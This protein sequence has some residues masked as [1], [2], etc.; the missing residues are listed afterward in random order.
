[1][2]LGHGDIS[3]SPSAHSRR[4]SFNIPPDCKKSLRRRL[5]LARYYYTRTPAGSERACVC[6]MNDPLEPPP[7]PAASIMDD[8]GA[9]WCAAGWLAGRLGARRLSPD[10]MLGSLNLLHSFLPLSFS[11]AVCAA[12]WV[13]ISTKQ[14]WKLNFTS[15]EHHLLARA[16]RQVHLLL[17][18]HARRNKVHC[19][20]RP[21]TCTAEYC[22]L[23][24][25]IISRPFFFCGPQSASAVGC[26]HLS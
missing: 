5:L 1:L 2:R 23:E 24:W 14:P 25:N 9:L 11:I 7:L 26:L 22:L 16:R 6:I 15:N 10:R 4:H 3:L 19:W 8:G 20:L 12:G 21:C 17:F 18:S 13:I